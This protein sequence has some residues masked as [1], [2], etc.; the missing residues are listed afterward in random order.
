MKI[1]HLITLSLVLLCPNGLARPGNADQV[2]AT[3]TATTPQQP[4]VRTK[5][6]LQRLS[7]QQV[8]LVGRY[9]RVISNKPESQHPIESMTEI[10]GGLVP[11]NPQSNAVAPRT[12]G[13]AQIILTDGTIVHI[14]PRGRRS[15]RSSAELIKYNTQ[16]VRAVG[17]IRW[18]GETELYPAEIDIF[19]LN[20]NSDCER[21]ASNV[22]QSPSSKPMTSTTNRTSVTNFDRTPPIG[23]LGYPLGQ[24]TTISGVVQQAALDTKS[25]SSDLL[26]KVEAINDRLLPKPVLMP[27]T[28]FETA[29]IAKPILGR[30]F[31]YMGY[32]TGGFTGVPSAAFKLVPAVATTNHH[33]EAMYQIL[34]EDL[35]QVKTQA[36]LVQFNGQRVQVIGK[37]VVTD[38]QKPNP[39]NT[40]IIGFK[41]EYIRATIELADGTRIALFSPDNKQ[42]LRSID[43][44]KTYE[45]KTVS[46]VGKIQM[47]LES[48]RSPTERIN[49]LT[50]MDGIW[51][52]TAQRLDER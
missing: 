26:L 19:Q 30:S 50:T 40:G 39:A 1:S 38:R 11:I 17:N 46:V 31:R 42:S 22:A 27:F 13:F 47:Q 4:I 10:P 33:F 14:S 49:I 8:T 45:G 44:V 41:G 5:V 6:D 32:E 3:D 24:I 28:V 15:L 29:Q 43:E 51:P 36:D 25:T 34:R 9:Q 52:A 23:V 2:C 37:Y 16:F 12:S 21:T 35:K 20:L 7:G 48:R 18:S